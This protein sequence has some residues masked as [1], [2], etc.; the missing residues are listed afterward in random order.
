MTPAV[1][2]KTHVSARMVVNRANPEGER[3]AIELHNPVE[4]RLGDF[5]RENLRMNPVMCATRTLALCGAGPSLPLEFES[6]DELW[7]CNSAL[8]YL[9]Q[10]GVR[11]DVGVGI[12]Q[13][14]GLLREWSDPPDVL[15]Y[16]ASTVDPELTRHL[17]AHGRQIRSFH[18]FVG[19]PGE[20]D[21][22]NEDWPPGFIVGEGATVVSRVIGLASWM[23]FHN[24][25]IYGADCAFGPDDQ[26]HANGDGVSQAYGNAVLMEGEIDG[27]TWRTRP[28]MLMGAVDLV[29]RSR[30]RTMGRVRMMGDTLPAALADKPET[31]LD[32]VMR[33]LTPGE[34]PP[35]G[36]SPNGQ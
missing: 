3:I 1:L 27:R 13:T 23:G 19:Y 17:L 36:D 10:Q 7:A 5:A 16:L 33:R 29:R 15:Y 24:V 8:P 32:A 25:D 34:L 28:D 11:V 22:Y 31:Y 6:H 2:R 14:P 4:H 35:T 30:N 21:E 9:V 18:N 20:M 12:D 26:V